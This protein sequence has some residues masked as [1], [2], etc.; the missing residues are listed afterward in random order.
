MIRS[1]WILP[2]EILVTTTED[3][4]GTRPCSTRVSR[5]ASSKK[6]EASAVSADVKDV[7]SKLVTLNDPEVVTSTRGTLTPV[8]ASAMTAEVTP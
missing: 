4:G 6:A 2:L 1:Y 5:I 3:P 8:L 7:V